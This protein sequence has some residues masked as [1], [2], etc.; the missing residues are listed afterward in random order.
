MHARCASSLFSLLFLVAALPACATTPPR[1][2]STSGAVASSTASEDALRRGEAESDA[3]TDPSDDDALDEQEKETLR[4][5]RQALGK[6]SAHGGAPPQASSA[7][8]RALRKTNAKLRLEPMPDRDGETH[9]GGLV[10][11]KD[12]MTERMAQLQSKLT[13][14]GLSRSEAREIQ[15]SVTTLKPIMELRG[16]ILDVSGQTTSAN[17]YVQHTGLSTV[18]K[19]AH[20]VRM[21][22]RMGVAWTD[23]DYARV[24]RYVERMR[25]AAAI[26]AAGL[27]TLAAYEAVINQGGDPKAIDAVAASA[28]QA[29]PW[30]PAATRDDARA[31]VENFRQNVGQEKAQYERMMRGIYGDAK[32]EKRHK[33]EVDAMFAQASDA[34]APSAASQAAYGPAAAP[35]GP[36]GAPSSTAA[37]PAKGGRDALAQ[38]ARGASVAGAAKDGDVAG[39]LDGAAQMFPDGGTLKSSLSGMAALGRG[40][41]RGALD[42]ALQLVPGGG[43]VKD[44]LS[45]AATLLFGGS[46]KKS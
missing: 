41:A 19:V 1:A 10:D 26:A 31:Y 6:A 17:L 44:G 28:V 3:R 42:A 8:I 18:L 29:F 34:D 2:V 21:R 4:A 35:A 11:L 20:M 38:V 16:E 39:A 27:G 43:L 22:T 5:L 15:E 30:K 25:R 12:S 9:E 23:E 13:A 32:Y 14:G 45:L 36:R 46:A 37:P 40:D 24:Q 7:C 33:A